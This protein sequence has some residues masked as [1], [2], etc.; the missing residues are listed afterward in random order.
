[1]GVVAIF[2][3]I[4]STDYF[5]LSISLLFKKE[6]LS[7]TSPTGVAYGVLEMTQGLRGK[8]TSSMCMG[9]PAL[10][11]SAPLSFLSLVMFVMLFLCRFCCL[12]GCC[13]VFV[14]SRVVFVCFRVSE[15]VLLHPHISVLCFCCGMLMVSVVFTFCSCSCWYCWEASGGQPSVNVCLV[16]QSLQMYSLPLKKSFLL[17]PSD[18]LRNVGKSLALTSRLRVIKSSEGPYLHVLQNCIFSQQ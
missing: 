6:G 8:S 9:V 4:L 12:F 15:C 11:S 17:T 3:L 16:P 13:V 1:M 18:V 10:M 2:V 7:R 14:C 5:S